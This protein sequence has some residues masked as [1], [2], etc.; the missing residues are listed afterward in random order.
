M[1]LHKLELMMEQLLIQHHLLK[2][3]HIILD[4]CVEDVIEIKLILLYKIIQWVLGDIGYLMDIMVVNVYDI[5]NVV[6]GRCN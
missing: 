4:K 3:Q 5:V 6:I 1:Q 2:I